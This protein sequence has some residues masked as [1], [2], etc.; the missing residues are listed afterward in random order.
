MQYKRT[1]D[2]GH[3]NRMEMEIPSSQSIHPSMFSFFSN[4]MIDWHVKYNDLMLTVVWN[5][6]VLT[7]NSG[8]SR[9]RYEGSDV[10]KLIACTAI[11][12]HASIHTMILWNYGQTILN[13]SNFSN[14]VQIY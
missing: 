7:K 11:L 13:S 14:V 4:S 10:N 5:H 3:I 8:K 2:Q 6:R 1:H 9:E 12:I